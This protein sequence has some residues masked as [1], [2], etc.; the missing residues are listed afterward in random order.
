MRGDAMQ[1]ELSIGL[2]DELN[3][4]PLGVGAWAWGSTRLWGYGK[5]YDRSDVGKAF[6]A[7]M[8]E[9]V[10]LLDTAEMYGNG[11]S[12]RIIGEILREGGFEGTPVIATKF[13]PLPY[14]INARSLLSAVEKSLER[15][16]IDTIDLYQIHFPTPI[17]KIKNLMD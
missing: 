15:L 1:S 5:E 16:G 10:T 4:A 2:A 13:A 9:G 3:V 8:A 17:L 11:A 14:R 6:R 7:S 12:E